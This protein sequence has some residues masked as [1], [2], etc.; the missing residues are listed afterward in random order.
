MSFTPRRFHSFGPASVALLVVLAGEVPASAQSRPLSPA[1]QEWIANTRGMPPADT[2][3]GRLTRMFEDAC[4]AFGCVGASVAVARQGRLAYSHGF[5]LADIENQVPADG[6]TVYNVGSVSKVMT[7]IAVMQLV[8][9]GRVGLDD[10]IRRWVPQFPDKGHEITLR[11]LMTH[12]SGIRH[13]R[14]DDFPEGLHGE[15]VQP[16]ASFDEALNLFKDDPLLFAPGELYFYSSY[17]INLLQGVIEAA[18]G[19]PFEAYMREH[20]WGPSGM[21]RTQ[22]DRPERIVPGRARSYLMVDGEPLNH[23]FEDVTYKFAS[24]GMLSTVEDLVRLASAFNSGRLLRPGTVEEMIRPQVETV[25]RFQGPG[26]PPVTESFRQALIWKVEWDGE[27]FAGSGPGRRFVSHGGSVKGF[28]CNLL[29]YVEED[30]AVAICG[31]NYHSPAF[32]PLVA[33]LFLAPPGSGR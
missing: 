28:G 21:L 15:N 31:N 5:G 26:E 8:E 23:P 33:D 1:V 12:T 29:S 17:A 4:A 11:H 6:N 24:G 16:F 30:V 13:Y 18:S 27:A 7:G 22:F 19:M 10:D 14:D 3:E 2:P 32:G 20:V 25:R 9:A